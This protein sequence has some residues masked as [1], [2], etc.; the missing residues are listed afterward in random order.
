MNIC[1]RIIGEETPFMEFP[2]DGFFA[3]LIKAFKG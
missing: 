3:R 1:K 2:V